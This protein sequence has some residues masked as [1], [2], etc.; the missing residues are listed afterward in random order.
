MQYR[1]FFDDAI[2]QLKK[3]QRRYRVFA[4]LA[5]DAAA[6]PSAL[7]RRGA[8]PRAAVDVTVWCSNDYLGMGQHPEVIDAMVETARQGRRR[9]RRHPQ[10]FRHQPRDRRTRARTRRSAR[11]GGGARLH[12]RLDLQ[13]RG[14]LDHRRSSAELPDPL[15]RLESQFDD[16]GRAGAR[17]P[18]RRSSAT[19]TSRISRSC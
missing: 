17:A 18:R 16:R 9:R 2:A 7:W 14:D 1:R 12:L 19:T 13:S 3:M 5:R 11:Q 4:D 15:R 8:D 6:Y 10:Y